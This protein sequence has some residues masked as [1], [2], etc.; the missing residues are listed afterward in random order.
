MTTVA[1]DWMEVAHSFAPKIESLRDQVEHQRQVPPSLISEMADAGIFRMTI[2]RG[3]GGDELGVIPFCRFV[4]EMSRS[5]GS[6]GWVAMIGAGGGVF[7]EYLPA[8]AARQI[9]GTDPRLISAGALAPRGRAV[10]VEGGYRLS[11][12]WPLASGCPEASWFFAG[13]FI[14]TDAGPRAGPDGGPDLHLFFLP[15]ADCEIIDTWDSL[16]LRGTASHDFRVDQAFV[17]EQFKFSVRHSRPTRSESQYRGPLIDVLAPPVAAVALGIARAA[18]DEFVVVAAT[19]VPTFGVTALRD[20]G[21]IQ[22]K[23]A[24]AEALLRS[25]RAFFYEVLEDLRATMARGEEPTATQAALRQLSC[26]HAALAAADA[27]D[28]IYS[29]AGATAVY[30]R[31]RIERCFR[32]VHSVTQHAAVSALGYEQAGR[33]FLGLEMGM[34]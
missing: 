13:A 22:A 11:G 26:T 30:A 17:P 25:A 19:K 33:V 28:L 20:R 2:P 7:A 21:T 15:K 24:Q 23:V 10:P 18:I 9:F 29:A 3:L 1:T 34:R 31:S 27:V 4:E 8:M 12:Q 16:G 32:D 5:D 6:T 14:A